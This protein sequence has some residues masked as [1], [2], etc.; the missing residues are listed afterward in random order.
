MSE[1]NFVEKC[2]EFALESTVELFDCMNL[3][4]QDEKNL[5]VEDCEMTL[6]QLDLDQ[7]QRRQSI[8]FENAQKQ[9]A[10]LENLLKTVEPDWQKAVEKPMTDGECPPPKAY[11]FKDI[12]ERKKQ[13]LRQQHLEE[14][15]AM[16][17]FHSR[18]MPNFSRVHRYLANRPIVHRI[19]CAVTPNV[20]KTSR[21]M[22]LKRKQRIEQMQR[23]QMQR[24][25]EQLQ[26]VKMCPKPKPVPRLKPAPLKPANAPL[27]LE[28]KP[29]RLSTELRAEQRKIF[30]AHSLET[31]EA[32]RRQLEEQRKRRE[33]EEFQKQRQ[34]ATFRARPNPFKYQFGGS[35]KH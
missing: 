15:R 12:Y 3:Q 22:L 13:K 8:V 25:Q 7:V 30:N 11:R 1:L 18:P 19:T 34:L 6:K 26:K 20:L 35:A 4:E 17:Q 32:K 27:Q 21:Q 9:V 24:E 33:E 16:R 28:V 14:E 5:S 31:Q 2:T 10:V 23:E 29:F